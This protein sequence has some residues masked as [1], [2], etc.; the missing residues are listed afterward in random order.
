MGTLTSGWALMAKG[1]VAGHQPAAAMPDSRR[2]TTAFA[3]IGEPPL[4]EDLGAFVKLDGSGRMDRS[5]GLSGL[6]PTIT[7]I[8]KHITPGARFQFAELQGNNF[9]TFK[10][11]SPVTR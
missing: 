6:Q 2:T 8:L 7:G 4:R 10:P 11:Q 1:L 5:M 9:T 3:F